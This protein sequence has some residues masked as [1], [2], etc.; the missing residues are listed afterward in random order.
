M[1][2][3]EETGLDSKIK[4]TVLQGMMSLR[5]HCMMLIKYFE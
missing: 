4:A 2:S 5:R 3:L 1:P